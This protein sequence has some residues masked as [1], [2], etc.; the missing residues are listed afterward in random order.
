MVAPTACV[1][2]WRTGP[3]RRP[4]ALYV[5]RFV[6]SCSAFQWQISGFNRFCSFLVCI[7]IFSDWLS[8][9]SPCMVGGRWSRHVHVKHTRRTETLRSCG[10]LR[11]VTRTVCVRLWEPVPTRTPRTRRVIPFSRL[12]RSLHDFCVCAISV[13]CVHLFSL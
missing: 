4:R 3:T 2:W 12:E 13:R 11:T 10:P 1:C 6:H 7:K 5:T 9:P 8:L